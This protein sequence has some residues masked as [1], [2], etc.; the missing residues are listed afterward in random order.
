M[1]TLVIIRVIRV[2]ACLPDAS[3]RMDE[4]F[5]SYIYGNMGNSV[6]GSVDAPLSEE[7]EI[8]RDEVGKVVSNFNPFTLRCLLGSVAGNNDIMEEQNGPYEAAAV[9]SFRGHSS[10]QVG[11]SVHGAGGRDYGFCAAVKRFSP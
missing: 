6:F 11:E 5:S 3:E 7:Y 2:K 8:P 1:V 10:P 4:S 9:H